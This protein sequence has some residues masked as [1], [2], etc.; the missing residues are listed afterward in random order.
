MGD[1]FNAILKVKKCNPKAKAPKYETD[2]AAGMDVSACIDESIIVYSG[3]HKII[4]TGLQVE[5]PP[6]FELQVRPRSGLAAKNCITVLNSPGTVDS[7][8]R[9]NLMVILINLGSRSFVVEPGDRIAQLI[10]S[11]VTRAAVMVVSE[12]GTTVRGEGGLGSTGVK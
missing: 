5:V 3:C 9:G 1:P 4:D 11:P 6:G 7:D 2:G 8:F 10:L 12:L